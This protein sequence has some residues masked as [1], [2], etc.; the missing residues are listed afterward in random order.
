METNKHSALGYTST[1]TPIIT[2]T[3]HTTQ[4]STQHTTQASSISTPSAKSPTLSMKGS[5][6]NIPDWLFGDGANGQVTQYPFPTQFPIQNPA[7]RPITQNPNTQNPTNPTNQNP[8]NQKPVQN[9]AE[10]AP[11]SSGQFEEQ[12]LKIVNSERAKSGLQALSMNE[13]LSKMALVKAQDMINNN[14]FDHNSPTYG[15]PFD[16]M[17]QYN[18]TYSYAGENI[19]KGQPTPQQVMNDWMNSPG[20]RANIMKSN[21]TKIGIGYYKGAWVQEFTG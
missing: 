5:Q 19:A 16:M 3:P 4:T 13:P 21:F 18:I 8:T 15:S 7:Q 14:Y 20:H 11:S 17:K 12:V 1:K 6:Y 10:K 2:S 9:P